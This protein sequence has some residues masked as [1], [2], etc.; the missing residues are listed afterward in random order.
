MGPLHLNRLDHRSI[1]IGLGP[2]AV[3]RYVND[4]I[5]AIT[6]ATDQARAIAGHLADGD[7]GTA[8]TLLPVERPYPLDAA[9]EAHIGASTATP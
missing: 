4:R 7:I 5:T 6:D 2:E 8:R 9:A 1:Q 3:D